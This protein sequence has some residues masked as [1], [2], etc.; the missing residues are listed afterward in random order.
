M[1]EY[2]LGRKLNLK[3]REKQTRKP[4]SQETK[5]KIRIRLMGNKNNTSGRRGKDVI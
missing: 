1:S 5:D 4:L 2:R 3:P